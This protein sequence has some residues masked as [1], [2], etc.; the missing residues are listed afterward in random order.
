M[1]AYI[2]TSGR[3]AALSARLP[4]ELSNHITETYGFT[5]VIRKD[6]KY[7]YIF[8]AYLQVAFLVFSLSRP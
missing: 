1:T 3:R 4:T 5:D 6:R 2:C 8:E 7:V